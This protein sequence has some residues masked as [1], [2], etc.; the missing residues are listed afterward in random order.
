[1]LKRLSLRCQ[2]N[3]CII[4]AFC[5]GTQK[6]KSVQTRRRSWRPWR[7]ANPSLSAHPSPLFWIVLSPPS[8]RESAAGLLFGLLLVIIEDWLDDSYVIYDYYCSAMMPH[9]YLKSGSFTLPRSRRQMD[10]AEHQLRLTANRLPSSKLL[11][12]GSDRN[13]PPYFAIHLSSLTP[14]S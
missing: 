4:Y 1:M 10:K 3:E 11:R 8:L 5:A 14:H 7:P 6:W 12:V 9:T 2:A 13:S